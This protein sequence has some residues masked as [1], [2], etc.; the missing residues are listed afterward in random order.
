MVNFIT[1]VLSICSK[2]PGDEHTSETT[3]TFDIP[4]TNSSVPTHDTG[5]IPPVDIISLEREIND[6]HFVRELL[7]EMKDDVGVKMESLELS[8]LA[9]DYKK[10]IISAHSIKGISLSMKCDEIA[11]CSSMVEESCV[12][13][14][15]GTGDVS[16]DDIVENLDSLKTAVN[17]FYV[18]YN[19][20]IH[21]E[22]GT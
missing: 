20:Y 15:K 1:R 4:E 21:D 18:F 11:R 13:L 10:V 19:D 3:H 2:P 14:S 5:D 9:H 16:N 22:D 7:L 6:L 8:L 12:K 17:S